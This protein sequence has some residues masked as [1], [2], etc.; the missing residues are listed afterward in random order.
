ML[1]VVAGAFNPS[2]Q[3]AGRSLGV[4]TSLTYTVSSRVS[5]A[6]K[7]EPVSSERGYGR[8]RILMHQ[9]SIPSMS[10]LS[11]AFSHSSFGDIDTVFTDTLIL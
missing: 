8:E 5:S 6:T 11:W 3:E 7:R 10:L 9:M 2:T 4:W 1:G